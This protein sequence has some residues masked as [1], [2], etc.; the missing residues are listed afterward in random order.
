MKS[1]K[2]KL[3]RFCYFILL[4]LASAGIGLSGG[5]PIPLFNKKEDYDGGN[6]EMVE[7]KKKEDDQFMLKINL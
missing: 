1:F 4:I 3:R 6:I 2:R 7:N 5:V